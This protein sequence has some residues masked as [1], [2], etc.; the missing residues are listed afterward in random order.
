MSFG[1]APADRPPSGRARLRPALSAP[2]AGA[3][4]TYSPLQTIELPP[5]ALFAPL[6]HMSRGACSSGRPSRSAGWGPEAFGLYSPTTQLYSFHN[7]ANSFVIARKSPLCFHNLTNCFSRI[8]FLLITLQIA[9]G[10]HP[11]SANSTVFNESQNSVRPC[12]RTT[13][14][15]RLHRRACP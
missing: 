6:A 14:R 9:G 11:P 5:A 8:R 2:P 12:T 3:G 7:L 4:C 15:S 1:T 13:A 10:C